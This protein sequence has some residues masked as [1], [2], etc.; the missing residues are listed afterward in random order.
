MFLSILFYNWTP[1]GSEAIILL[2]NSWGCCGVLIL[3]LFEELVG[4]VLVAVLLHLGEVALLRCHCSIHLLWEEGNQLRSLLNSQHT[5]LFLKAKINTQEKTGRQEPVC[6]ITFCWDCKTGW[7]NS[8]TPPLGFVASKISNHQ[9]I[10]TNH[11][12]QCHIHTALGH[13]QGW[14]GDS[15]TSLGSHCHCLTALA[16]KKWFLT[17]NLKLPWHN[18]RPFPLILLLLPRRRGWPTPEHN[19]HSGSCRER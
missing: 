8:A 6:N 14:Y 11:V 18:L 10:P 4:G 17:P 1:M 5:S 16:E 19:L 9:P 7:P 3:H 12:P 15:T 2:S 13:L